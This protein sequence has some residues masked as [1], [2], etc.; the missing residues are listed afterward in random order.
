[1]TGM[2]LMG[3]ALGILTITFAVAMVILA[4]MMT[5]LVPLGTP[6]AFL[7]VGLAAAACCMAAAF[8]AELFKK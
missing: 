1:M 8:L 3:I 7:F 6:P 5:R 2:K 4:A